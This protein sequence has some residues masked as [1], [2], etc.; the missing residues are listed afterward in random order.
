MKSYRYLRSA[1][2]GL[3]LCLGVAVFFQTAK[4]GLH[5][6]ASVS[7]YYYTP[8][9]AIFVG[10]LIGMAVCMIALQGTTGVE[11]MFLNLGGMCAA[12]VAIVPT[13]RGEDYRTAVDACADAAGPLMTE[14]A[15]GGADCPTVLALA[16]ATRANVENNMVALL[17]VG[18]LGLVAAVLFARRD[19]ATGRGFRWAFAVAA[20]AYAA[21]G[22]AFAVSVSWFVDYAHY[23]SAIGLFLCIIVVTVA[24][25]LRHGGTGSGG[26]AGVARTLRAAGGVLVRPPHRFDRYAWIAWAMVVVAVAGAVLVIVNAFA[27]F[28]LEIAVALLFAVFWTVQTIEQLPRPV[29]AAGTDPA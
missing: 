7:A 8:A 13:S 25:A 4:Q 10:A 3:L 5:P 14:K 22:V 19:G 29:A 23:V 21:A 6:L 18:L 26:A 16:D 15:A 1:L 9:Q 27:L 24:N 20:T 28:W 12:V 17:A 11:E 2:V